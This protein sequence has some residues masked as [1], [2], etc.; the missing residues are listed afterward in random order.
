MQFCIT[1]YYKFFSPCPE[2]QLPVTVEQETSTVAVEQV[3]LSSLIQ[4]IV[5]QQAVITSQQEQL[6]SKEKQ[7]VALQALLVSQ[8]QTNQIQE[9]ANRCLWEE[10]RARPVP[11]PPD[12]GISVSEHTIP[13]VVP[14]KSVDSGVNKSFSKTAA[15]KIG[16][17]DQDF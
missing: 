13:S 9:E 11:G 16:V 5:E 3:P 14:A 2:I 4:V 1:L 6:A 17:S 7:I 15:L 10:L 8:Q 12:S